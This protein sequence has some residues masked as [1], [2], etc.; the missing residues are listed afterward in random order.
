MPERFQIVRQ[1]MSPDR[2]TMGTLEAGSFT[3]FTLEDPWLDNQKGV[4]CIPTGVYKVVIDISNRF[5]R[6]MPHFLDVPGREGIRVHPGN[7]E[8]DT[9]GCI[10]VGLMRTDSG[11][12]YSKPGFK[13]FYNWLSDSLLDG[14]VECEVTCG[15]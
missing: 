6:P 10:L 13:L 15:S 9:E 1:W 7:N 14:P 8:C 12:I 11:V 5:Q 3:L 4:S 2:P